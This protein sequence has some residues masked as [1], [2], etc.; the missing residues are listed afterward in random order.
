MKAAHKRFGKRLLCIVLFYLL[1]CGFVWGILTVQTRSYNRLSH[2]PAAMAQLLL[3]PDSQ[4]QLKLADQTLQ[5]KLPQPEAQW[6]WVAALPDVAGNAAVLL[7][8]ILS[9]ALA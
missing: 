5:W 7:W 6:I 3:L 2:E 9:A 4:A 8:Q 1:F